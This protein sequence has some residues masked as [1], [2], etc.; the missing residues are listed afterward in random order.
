[1]GRNR[2]RHG[3]DDRETAGGIVMTFDSGVGHQYRRR[4]WLERMTAGSAARA[5]QWLRRP[6][7]RAYGHLLSA[8]PGD[9]LVCRLPGGEAFRVDPEYRHLAW[10]AE[11]Y[12]AM[13]AAVRPGAVVLDAGANIG[14]Y[15]LLFA[16]WAG[17]SGRVIAFEPATASRTG[18][19][20]HLRLNG[21]EARVTIR[22][23]A[24]S[25]RRGEASFVE[26]STHGDNR[27][28]AHAVAGSRT[29]P[30][31]TIDDVCSDLGLEPDV[32]KIDIEGAELAALRGAR[33][34][35]AARGG[36]PAVFVELHPATWPSLG[37]TRADIEAEL[38]LQRLQVEPLP[39]VSD[40]WN[41][42]GVCVR[43]RHL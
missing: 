13:K 40:P 1:M 7:K 30:S 14:A 27:L 2:S 20:R 4:S 19:A 35:I 29:V 25:D 26:D 10:N 42:Q 5:P 32:I 18:L 34:T 11:E 39:G 9:H 33:Q 31:T 3:T 24:I 37:V 6:L 17:G 43:L 23:E 38:R 21:L 12:A 22:A 41:T 28:V 36:A 15:T 16:T 8:L